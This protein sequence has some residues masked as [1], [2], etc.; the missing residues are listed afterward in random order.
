MLDLIFSWAV[1]LPRTIYLTSFILTHSRLIFLQHFI[2]H[3]N[4][5]SLI[6]WLLSPETCV[7]FI[8]YRITDLWVERCVHKILLIILPLQWS[9]QTTT[10]FCSWL[11]KYISAWC[12]G[13]QL[14][15]LPLEW[16]QPGLVGSGIVSCRLT[17]K[18]QVLDVPWC[19]GLILALQT[20][21][22]RD[23]AS[24]PA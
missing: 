18:R 21:G 12:H 9:F 16:L 17:L 20:G 8:P 11:L 7:I 24:I 19:Q 6:L 13:L 15:K 23:D 14:I 1:N 2:F 10:F 4:F 5:P 22:H 3:S